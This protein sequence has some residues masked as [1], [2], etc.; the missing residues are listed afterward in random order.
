VGVE[1]EDEAHPGPWDLS[2]HGVAPSGGVD[3]LVKD[4]EAWDWLCGYW[5]SDEFKAILERNRGRAR[6]QCTTTAR[7]DMS[8]RRRGW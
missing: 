8:A 2:D 5:A 4:S 6:P 1:A 3:W 7:M